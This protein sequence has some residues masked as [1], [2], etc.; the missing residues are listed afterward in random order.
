MQFHAEADAVLDALPPMFE[1][2]ELTYQRWLLATRGDRLALV[3]ERVLFVAGDAGESEVLGLTV[4]ECD[5]KGLI[6]A[7]SALIPT[8]STAHTTCWTRGTS[9]ARRPRRPAVSSRVRR[10]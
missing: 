5:T 4:V 1:L 9:S 7:T 6:V 2:D 3:R 10:A 8:T